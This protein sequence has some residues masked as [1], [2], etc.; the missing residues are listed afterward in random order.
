[1]FVRELYFVYD[2]LR[3]LVRV[4]FFF[5]DIVDLLFDVLLLIRKILNISEKDFFLF[6][7]Y[8]NF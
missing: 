7:K 2:I 6:V 4:I 3:V 1:M 8:V 5:V